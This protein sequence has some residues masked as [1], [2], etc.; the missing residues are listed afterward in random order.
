[1]SPEVW[2]CT[3]GDRV[4]K[5]PGDMHGGWEKREEG[6]RLWSAMRNLGSLHLFSVLVNDRHDVS[7]CW[8]D[9]QVHTPA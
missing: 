6:N 1:M 4:V 8:P 3:V 9:L 2:V 5:A 7:H